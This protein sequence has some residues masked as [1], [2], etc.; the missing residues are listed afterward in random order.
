MD[1]PSVILK[2]SL[3]LTARPDFPESE[4]TSFEEWATPFTRVAI[5]LSS[6]LPEVDPAAL[7]AFMEY[8]TTQL[9]FATIHSEYLSESSISKPSDLDFH[10]IQR[11]VELFHVSPGGFTSPRGVHPREA[12]HRIMTFIKEAY[13]SAVIERRDLAIRPSL[14][15]GAPHQIPILVGA[16]AAYMLVENRPPLSPEPRLAVYVRW[17]RRH[18]PKDPEHASRRLLY[19]SYDNATE[20]HTQG[21]HSI[22]GQ[23]QTFVGQVIEMTKKGG[24]RP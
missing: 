16:L 14:L 20:F 5:A 12:C 2:S 8:P 9:A 23:L 10:A 7:V 18:E 21:E 15:S 6:C 22:A 3:D 24:T 19:F 17:Q 1:H 4:R 13:A 11:A